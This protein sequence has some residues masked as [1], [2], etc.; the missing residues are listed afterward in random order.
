[1][2]RRELP[3]RHG[4]RMQPPIVARVAVECASIWMPCRI[5]IAKTGVGTT[6]TV[7]TVCAATTDDGERRQKRCEWPSAGERLTGWFTE[8]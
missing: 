3:R 4:C 5:A 1:V 8:C 6:T 2:R 7:P